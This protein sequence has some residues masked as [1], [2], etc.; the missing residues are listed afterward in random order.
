METLAF[1]LIHRFPPASISQTGLIPV[2]TESLLFEAYRVG[3]ATLSVFLGGQNVSYFAMSTTANYT[4]YGVD[5]S[6]FAGQTETLNFSAFGPGSVKNSWT[7]D[8]IL[9]SS[10]PIPEPSL[11]WLFLLGGGVFLYALRIKKHSRILPTMCR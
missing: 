2:G 6:A 3:P 1:S 4:V 5:I 10:S 8:D 7:I 11:S 9:F